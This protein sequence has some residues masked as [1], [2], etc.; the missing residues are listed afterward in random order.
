MTTQ[1]LDQFFPNKPRT[2]MTRT[3]LFAFSIMLITAALAGTPPSD[4]PKEATSPKKITFT[5]NKGQVSDQHYLPRPDVRFYGE[6]GPM[7]FHITDGGISYQLRRVETWKAIEERDMVENA[8]SMDSI[9]DRIRFRR[10]DIAWPGSDPNAKWETSAPEP[11]HTNY[12][13]AVC[14]D[15]VTNVK[16]YGGLLR[17]DIYPGI[18]LKYYSKDGRL[19]YD[20]IVQ[21]GAAP[22]TIRLE[23]TGAEVSIL[24]N[25]SVRL[26]TPLGEIIEEPP[27]A[28]QNGVE[29][30]AK[31]A[32][33]GN[34]LSFQIEDH[35]PTF[36]L[37]IDPAVRTGGTYY[38]GSDY[39]YVQA[40]KTTTDGYVMIAGNTYS[41]A[42]IAT[43][44][45]GDVTFNGSS[46]GFVARLNG[47]ATRVWGTYFG[48]T[49][50]ES[51]W[52]SSLN[53]ENSLSVCGRTA[54]TTAISATMFAHQPSIGGGTDGFLVR[55][56]YDDGWRTYGSYYGGSG[57]DVATGC[58]TDAYNMT[59][60]TGTTTSTSAIS[61]P[62]AHLEV[63]PTGSYTG[64]LAKFSPSGGR[65]W[66]T[67][68]PGDPS[69]VAA[70]AD[71]ER[72]YMTGST[73]NASGISTIGAFLYTAPVGTPNGFI[74]AFNNTGSRLWGTYYGG[75]GL[76]W[77]Y[78]ITVDNQG[79]PIICGR[80]TSTTGIASLG[81]A[82]HGEHDGF[83]AKFT[84][85]GARLWGR[86]YGAADFDWLNSVDCD[87]NGNIYVGGETTSPTGLGSVNSH[88]TAH[89]GG[90][91]D[92]CLARISPE[93]VE[94]WSTYYGGSE[95][96]YVLSVAVSNVGRIYA[97]GNSYSTTSIAT[98]PGFMASNQGGT[99]GFYAL[100]CIPPEV[101]SVTLTPPTNCNG[102]DGT[103]T[104][105]YIGGTASFDVQWNGA[106]VIGNG[107]TATL[108]PGT[109]S[110]T[111]SSSFWCSG[112][113]TYNFTMDPVPEIEYTTDVQ[114]V[115]CYG[116]DNGA[117][118]LTVTHGTAP[119][120]YTWMNGAYTTEDISGL[121][122]NEYS[123]VITDANGCTDEATATIS[124][125]APLF[126][127]TTSAYPVYC[128]GGNNGSSSIQVSGGTEPITYL[129]SNGFQDQDPFGQTAG[130]YSV[131]MTD[132]NGCTLS[133]SLEITEPD[134]LLVT[135]I[136]TNEILGGDGSITTQVT[137]GYE[138]HTYLWSNGAVTSNL[139]G[140][141]AGTY[142][143]VVTDENQCVSFAEFVVE[144]T[145]GIAS[146]SLN[147]WSAFLDRNAQT[148]VVT[149]SLPAE[150]VV[151]L[152]ASGRMILSQKNPGLRNIL[153]VGHLAPAI[154]YV[155]V[156][157]TEGVQAKPI[158]ITP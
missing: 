33:R 93:G 57:Y 144:S 2:T 138:T 20:Y 55:F 49:Q 17:K 24:P 19:K 78:S 104:V 114:N 90:N 126:A 101:I 140:L 132:A 151:L 35:D 75:T 47:F 8:P 119:Y 133:H 11:D 129:W 1:C 123:C 94:E 37:I 145:V 10:I 81:S 9:P 63:L 39:D 139:Q 16:S 91:Y 83:V 36:P 105:N 147:D 53:S 56:A 118:D 128:H 103:A 102:N 112:S 150:Q 64:F 4:I 28:F 14:P 18:D 88:Q 99:D 122:P 77:P 155:Q 110:V 95:N 38:G 72:I 48:G 30:R 76:D 92:G 149:T 42:G 62:G 69:S 113:D 68:Y 154:Y 153:P 141:F 79:N 51:V 50:A 121:S 6:Q 96:D 61:T 44:G 15:G 109:Y 85:L 106:G 65:L 73:S 97:A 29:L 117:I 59:Y 3:L 27:L 148:L 5:E 7:S 127:W 120:S 86:Y 12:Y 80:T 40:I 134:S 156:H 45:A 158:L 135:G 22:G 58:S 136:V 41:T 46:D 67:Y 87:Q 82:L 111:V 146:H 115:L 52:S 142:S 43:S 13:L 143:L 66:G 131:V 116:D 89:G 71:G 60:L 84:A 31:W 124:E 32:L 107:P 21:P 25:G 137:G 23:V 125:P 34:V 54:S 100:F 108:G 74:T 130:V 152:D 98:G 26:S 70:S 157:T